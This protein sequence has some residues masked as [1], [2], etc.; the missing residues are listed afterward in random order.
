MLALL[1]CGAKHENTLVK[2]TD[3]GTQGAQPQASPVANAPEEV[4]S[5][6]EDDWTCLK[7]HPR[8]LTDANSPVSIIKE[9]INAITEH[10]NACDKLNPL[11]EYEQQAWDTWAQAVLDNK[12]F[13]DALKEFAKQETKALEKIEEGKYPHL[14]DCLLLGWNL[15]YCN[16]RE[17]NAGVESGELLKLPRYP[18]ELEQGH[19]D[20]FE[21]L[22]YIL[23]PVISPFSILHVNLNLQN[24]F[25]LAQV[26]KELGQFGE[27]MNAILPNWKSILD[28]IYDKKNILDQ[29]NKKLFLSKH[30][31]II[32][33]NATWDDLELESL[34]KEWFNK[35]TVLPP[36]W[37]LPIGRPSADMRKKVKK[38]TGSICEW[39]W[40]YWGGSCFHPSFID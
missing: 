13:L 25:H 27:R 17:L 10:K 39:R 20:I 18:R 4:E 21:E 3:D 5:G 31:F 35:C 38:A 32:F 29:L 9:Y 37:L 14:S 40:N 23:N 24:T 2:N 22:E 28:E 15:R 30:P 33:R 7:P 11:R 1:G 16:L 19:Q 8:L 12:A 36:C 34:K 26:K 6:T